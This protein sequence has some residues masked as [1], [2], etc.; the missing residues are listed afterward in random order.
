M[1]NQPNYDYNNDWI[2]HQAQPDH[3]PSNQ[4]L[5]GPFT[6]SQP[7]HRHDHSP[8]PP[9]SH[10]TF[11][12]FTHPAQL[13]TQHS[14]GYG[15]GSPLAHPPSMNAQL[16]AGHAQHKPAGLLAH[17]AQNGQ[18]AGIYP[19]SARGLVHDQFDGPF[20]DRTNLGGPNTYRSQQ[21]LGQSVNP[22]DNNQP[23]NYDTYHASHQHQ[24]HQHQ[25]QHQQLHRHASLTQLS[26]SGLGGARREGVSHSAGRLAGIP[27]G[28]QI[29]V[30]STQPSPA[31]VL[32]NGIVRPIPRRL[33]AESSVHSSR[34]ESPGPGPVPN[35]LTAADSIAREGSAAPGTATAPGGA[36]P[37]PALAKSA[38]SELKPLD[39]SDKAAQ[40][41]P[42]APSQNGVPAARGRARGAR[43]EGEAQR[44]P[45]QA[46]DSTEAAMHLLRLALPGN[47]TGGSVATDK[48][49]ADS[50]VEG[51]D[52]DAE[53]EEDRQSDDTSVHS[54]DALRSSALG[55]APVAAADARLWNHDDK[56]EPLRIPVHPTHQNSHSRQPSITSS[57][58]ST[59]KRQHRPA[60]TEREQSVAASVAGSSGSRRDSGGAQ[61]AMAAPDGRRTSGRV[62][63]PVVPAGDDSLYE[64][65]NSIDSGVNV[66]PID[67]DMFNSDGSDEEASYSYSGSVTKGKG[68]AKAPPKARSATRGKATKRASM[69][70]PT[71]GTD[72]GPPT[73]KKPR[74]SAP[75]ALDRT[76]AAPRQP[77]RVV[78]PPSNAGQRTFPAEVEVHP[79][80]PRFYRQFPISS[81]FPPDSSVHTSAIAQHPIVTAGAVLTP[82]QDT[83]WNKVSDPANLYI[84][85][86]VQGNAEHK[87]G[88]CPICIEPVARGGEGAEKWLKLKNSSYV[89][90]L[91]YAHGLS[92]L[93]GKPF[94]P[95]VKTRV[96]PMPAGAKDSRSEMTE[97][98]C[99]KCHGWIP[100]LSVKNVDAIVPELLWWKHSKKCHSESTIVGESDP[101]LHDEVY[102]LI[103]GGAQAGSG[104]ASA[105]SSAHGSAYGSRQLSAAGSTSGATGLDSQAVMHPSRSASPAD[106]HAS[107]A[108]SIYPP[109]VSP[110]G[111]GFQSP[112]AHQLQH[113]HQGQQAWHLPGHGSAGQQHALAQHNPQ[114]AYAHSPTGQPAAP[115]PQQ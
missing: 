77:R 71:V 12:S 80:F 57:V 112:Y 81:S 106:S 13:P 85:R 9:I 18:S 110:Y 23:T 47:S 103:I 60:R 111:D 32:P 25:H 105:Q 54:G 107:R 3:S 11:P 44:T 42:A 102:D 65:E 90:H 34:A 74:M 48:T 79:A 59:R 4:P 21:E 15:P 98:L 76:P 113:Q 41:Q 62:R 43:G 39:S 38:K 64:N 16:S 29:D 67:E 22:T 108:S 95:P 73:A 101:F 87:A 68:K 30:S 58:A 8:I 66:S 33:S 50:R 100:L 2:A 14:P 83:K 40:Q 94:S 104:H 51:D 96:T 46:E 88:L 69:G 86:V 37:S 55:L 72:L 70:G 61:G 36:Q 84:A 53:G 114:A 24:H 89:Y 63:K 6:Q 1:I 93:T 49:E 35:G 27:S 5:P 17:A 75:A 10:P 99:H 26:E 20:V 28:T 82:T 31:S 92:N 52:E 56:R 91:S 7:I 19:D 78:P 115:W 109:T 97:G 45:N